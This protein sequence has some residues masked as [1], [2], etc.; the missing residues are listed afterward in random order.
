VTSVTSDRFFVASDPRKIAVSQVGIG[1]MRPNQT[2]SDNAMNLV[3][4]NS[5]S[6]RTSHG[7]TCEM[8][9]NMSRPYERHTLASSALN[10]PYARNDA[11]Y[12]SVTDR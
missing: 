7:V 12:A 6:L 2:L 1:H 8:V 4:V 5:D 3:F 9:M 11:K 10:L